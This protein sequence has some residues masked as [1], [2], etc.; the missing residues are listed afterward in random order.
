VVFDAIDVFKAACDDAG[1][2]MADAAMRWSPPPP[3]SPLPPLSPLWL[4]VALPPPANSLPS[5]P[6]LRK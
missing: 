1:I 6:T 4:F 5:L 2:P 3:G